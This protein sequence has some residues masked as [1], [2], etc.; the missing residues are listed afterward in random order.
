MKIK[1]NKPVLNQSDIV[2]LKHLCLYY[3]WNLLLDDRKFLIT[4]DED[5]AYIQKEDKKLFI[6]WRKT[7][8]IQMVR[9]LMDVTACIDKHNLLPVDVPFK[10]QFISGLRSLLRWKTK[11]TLEEECQKLGL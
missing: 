10:D 9:D 3:G 8:Y 7:E 11:V 2:K 5:I 1:L 4:T 6:I